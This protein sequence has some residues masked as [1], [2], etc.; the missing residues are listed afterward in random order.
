MPRGVSRSE[1]AIATQNETPPDLLVARKA[2][3]QKGQIATRQLRACG[4]NSQAVLLRVRK[5]WLHPVFRGVYS[6]GHPVAMREGRFMAA[7]LAAATRHGVSNFAARTLLDLAACS[8][9][10]SCAPPRGGRRRYTG[11]P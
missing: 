2:E 4:L 5:G 11:S 1:S 7:V 8:S 10:R 6:V 3:E 9:P